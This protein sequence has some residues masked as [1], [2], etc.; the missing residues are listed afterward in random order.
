[1]Y[2]ILAMQE[3]LKTAKCKNLGPEMS[4]AHNQ[5]QTSAQG[6]ESFWTLVCK[7]IKDTIVRGSVH[8]KSAR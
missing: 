8:Q 1:M 7:A 5:L 4:T 3:G 2:K 6:P